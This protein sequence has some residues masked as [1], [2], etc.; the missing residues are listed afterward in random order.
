MECNLNLEETKFYLTMKLESII[1]IHKLV[2]E[3]LKRF[4]RAGITPKIEDL[5]KLENFQGVHLNLITDLKL[6]LES[7]HKEIK[8]LEQAGYTLKSLSRGIITWNDNENS[9][10]WCIFES[11]VTAKSLEVTA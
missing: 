8:S 9:Y 7:I 5:D 10:E 1:T 6:C 2:D 3:V 11:N 4:D